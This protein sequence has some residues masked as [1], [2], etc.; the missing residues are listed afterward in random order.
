MVPQVLTFLSHSRLGSP[1]RHPASGAAPLEERRR[2]APGNKDPGVP[3]SV[4]MA[5]VRAQSSMC[6]YSAYHMYI[7]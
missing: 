4:G 7:I 5:M 2:A 1:C 6:K 3:S